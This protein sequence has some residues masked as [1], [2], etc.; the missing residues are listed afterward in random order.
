MIEIV[1]ATRNR[2]K[3]EEILA[4]FGELNVRFRNVKFRT[5]ADFPPAP[6]VLEDGKTLKEN[7]LKKAVSAAAGTGKWALA[8]DT[9]LE[10]EFLRGAPGVNSARFAGPGCDYEENNKKLISVLSGVPLEKRKA[11]F[12][13]VMALASPDGKKITQE[14]EMRGSIGLTPCG[15]NGFGYD[16]LF[17]VP[18]KGRPPSRNIRKR[19]SCAKS[20]GKTFAELSFEE[21]NLISH[22]ARAARKMVRH[23]KKL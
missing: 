3:A 17:V 23:I 21:K 6:D 18:E 10:V 7:A 11:V 9:G 13:C 22:R 1:I 15:D 2:H 14:G 19:Q 12:R 5:L 16:S 20:R 4:I 8:D